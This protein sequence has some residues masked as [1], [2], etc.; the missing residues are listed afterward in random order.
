MKG[1]LPIQLALRGFKG[2]LDECHR[3][4]DYRDAQSTVG[5]QEKGVGAQIETGKKRSDN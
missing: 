3:P 4:C 5:M 1:H 2:F